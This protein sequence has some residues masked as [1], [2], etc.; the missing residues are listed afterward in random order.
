MEEKLRHGCVTIKYVCRQCDRPVPLE[1]NV[2][3]LAHLRRGM[4]TFSMRPCRPLSH[5]RPTSRPRI[6]HSANVHMVSR[7]F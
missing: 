3:K 2:R 1:G 4:S 5:T 6:L 7:V